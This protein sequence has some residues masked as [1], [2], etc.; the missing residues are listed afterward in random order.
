MHVASLSNDECHDARSKSNAPTAT[1]LSL[2]DYDTLTEP[3]HG[4]HKANV[5]KCFVPLKKL[6]LKSARRSIIFGITLVSSSIRGRVE[7]Y[8]DAFKID[9]HS[10]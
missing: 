7:L 4:I 9:H 2:P 10:Q 3:Y 8:D 1:F 5:P 6:S